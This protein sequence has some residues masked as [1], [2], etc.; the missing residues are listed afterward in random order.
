MTPAPEEDCHPACLTCAEPTY[1]TRAKPTPH[2]PPG[3]TTLPAIH[4]HSCSTCPRTNRHPFTPSTTQRSPEPA[5]CTAWKQG[6]T[7]GVVAAPVR[8]DQGPPR[9]VRELVRGHRTGISRR[10]SPGLRRTGHDSPGRGAGGARDQPWRSAA[11]GRSHQVDVVA[12]EGPLVNSSG[13]G[14]DLPAGGL[15]RKVNCKLKGQPGK[16]KEKKSP[17]WWRGGREQPLQKQGKA[18]TVI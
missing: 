11:G 15:S 8:P 16:K 9:I 12:N 5:P 3:I 10:D 17:A 4:P 7:A 6:K 13:G 2:V 1:A 14:R 18:G